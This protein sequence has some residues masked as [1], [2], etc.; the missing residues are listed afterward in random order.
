MSLFPL[1]HLIF[2]RWAGKISSLPR[3]KILAGQGK[4]KVGLGSRK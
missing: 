2:L 1:L 4:M 3:K